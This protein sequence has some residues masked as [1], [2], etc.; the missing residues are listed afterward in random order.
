VNDNFMIQLFDADDE[1]GR[2]ERPQADDCTDHAFRR[3]SYP[4]Q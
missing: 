1:A 4:G 2:A 3:H